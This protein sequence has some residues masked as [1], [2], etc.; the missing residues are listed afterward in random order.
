M[1]YTKL[2]YPFKWT[3]SSLGCPEYT[4][5]DA[6]DL[7]ARLGM[8]AVELRT[9][10]KTV[11]LPTLFT[12][13]FGTPEKLAAHLLEKGTGICSLDTSLKLVGNTEEDREAFL[14]FIP[15]AEAVGCKHLRIFD[16]GKTV[17]ELDN[18]TLKEIQNTLAWWR[19]YR[20]ENNCLCDVMVET[21]DCLCD[22]KAIQQVQ[23]IL[24]DPVPL[25]WDTHH[26]WKKAGA[27]LK[28][29]WDIVKDAT[30]HLHIKD[31]ISEPSDRHPFTY[32]FPGEGEFPLKDLLNMVKEDG[33]SKCVSLEWE[34]QWHPYLAPLPEALEKMYSLLAEGK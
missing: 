32:V 16:G 12:E 11:D 15:W 30:V 29:T 2:E 27:D 23:A 20:R 34:R 10:N 19:N 8:D 22:P 31:S 28:E 26:T 3:F 17:P 1:N 18:E 24:D 13:T 14:A 4:L 7:A 6:L 21:H 5:D 25:L 9:L 33:F